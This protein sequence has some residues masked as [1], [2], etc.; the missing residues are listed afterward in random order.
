M[1]KYNKNWIINVVLGI[2]N[3]VAVINYSL[4][5]GIGKSI[6][7][8]ILNKFV[9]PT[10]LIDP[11]MDTLKGNNSV[12]QGNVLVCLEEFQVFSNTVW[13][14][15]SQN[16]KELITSDTYTLKFNGSNPIPNVPN[17]L[18]VIINTNERKAIPANNFARRY[19][20]NYCQFPKGW[21]IKTYLTQFYCLCENS[22][23][24]G[25]CFYS[26][27]KENYDPNFNSE[28]IPYFNLSI[29]LISDNIFWVSR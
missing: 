5:E 18:S 3:K 26:Y 17:A 23:Q 27:C 24:F 29:G 28:I 19:M 20:F 14:T 22:P 15:K 16:L 11:R 13:K 8:V 7:P 12:L 10:V 4:V 25:R 6:I 2:K 1:F 21:D 9:C